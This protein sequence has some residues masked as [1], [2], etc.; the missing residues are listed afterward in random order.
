[1]GVPAAGRWGGAWGSVWEWRRPAHASLQMGTVVCPGPPSCPLPP[2][3]RLR[4][5][6]LPGP[7]FGHKNPRAKLH[8]TQTGH[9]RLANH[10]QAQEEQCLE[11]N[12]I[13]QSCKGKGHLHSFPTWAA[14]RQA[15]CSHRQWAW[16]WKHQQTASAWELNA[17]SP[18]AMQAG[19]H[20]GVMA[21]AESGEV[22]GWA[23]MGNT[24][25]MELSGAQVLG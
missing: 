13:K 21:Q 18:R 16:G 9:N 12:V 20:G 3:I 4:T 6:G 5:K 8:Q 1:M 10:T 19:R 14:G 7:M 22:V 24:R 17:C 23:E 11:L 2:A 25:K 15:S